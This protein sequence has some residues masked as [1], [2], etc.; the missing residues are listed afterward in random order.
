MSTKSFDDFV[1]KRVNEAQSNRSSK[2]I[3]WDETLEDWIQ[4]LKDLYSRM[5]E[6]LRK[7][8]QSGEIQV[9]HKK[10][11]VSEEY[12][13]N[14][15]VEKLTFHIGNEKVVAKP[16][17]RL[18]IGATGRVDL[19]GARGTLRLVLLEKGGPAI[20]TKIKIGQKVEEE[21]SWHP[22]QNIEISERG[23]Y[24]ATLPPR[25]TTTA[26]TADT[27]RDALMELSDV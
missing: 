9:T 13:G 19:I 23:W 20:Q 7:Y 6:Y 12:L 11:Q 15:E 25:I 10:I 2:E 22:I 14:Y 26:L 5:E 1:K 27:F 3:D 4:S 21:T 17:G 8:T 16:I 24:I 18:M